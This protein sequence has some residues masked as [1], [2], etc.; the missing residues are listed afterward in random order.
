MK[1]ELFIVVIVFGLLSSVLL[2]G[3][4]ITVRIDPAAQTVESGQAVS[5]DVVV[6][7][8]NNLG[9][10]QFDI[11]FDTNILHVNTAT[12]GVFLG[13]TGRTVIPVGPDMNNSTNPGKITYGAATLGANTG[14]DGNGI[15]A[16]VEFTTQANGTATLELQNVQ[17]SDVDGQALTIASLSNGSVTVGSPPMGTAVTNTND[18]GEGS[19]RWAIEQ[20]NSTP[21]SDEIAFAIPTSDPGYEAA[22]GIWRI[23][24]ASELPALQDAGMNVDGWSQ[25]EVA[26]DVNPDGPEIVLDGS[27]T[28]EVISGL[29]VAA[30]DIAIYGL[31]I[32]NF[33]N[34]G[35]LVSGVKGTFISE[36]LIGTDHRGQNSAGN[37]DGILL[38]NGASETLVGSTEENHG[39]VISGN[40]RFGVFLSESSHNYIT[41][42]LIGI[43]QAETDTLGNLGHGI[44]IQYSS[45]SNHVLFNFIGGNGDGV[46]IFNSDS[47]EIMG[48]WIG[49]DSTFTLKYSQ[50]NDGIYLW[51]NSRYT[52]II[53]NVIGYNLEFGISIGSSNALYNH[54][55]ENS[56]S[57][58]SAAGIMTWSGGNNELA[59]PT[60]L[61]YAN[62][63]IQGQAQP[64]QII[65]VFADEADEG[66]VYLGYAESN[67]N[68]EFSIQL[69]DSPLFNNITATAT[70]I[71][72]NTSGFS[73]PF[74]ITAVEDNLLTEVPAKFSLQQNYPNPFNNATT[75]SYSVAA[76][77]KIR[78]RVFN[79]MGQESERLVDEVKDA[80]HYKISWNSSNDEKNKISSGIFFIK[81]EA[82]NY[83]QVI[84]TVLIK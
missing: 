69:N 50:Q 9:A 58:N 30:D 66:R 5:I 34:A 12:M 24:P 70:D 40:T 38:I 54:I 10:F 14:P 2:Y 21:E 76:R 72:G 79:M 83:N 46:A 17:L 11:V 60:I 16:S 26:G 78:I 43:N 28:S 18:S 71:N 75:I 37:N 4:D 25:Q 6:E 41:N 52:E 47:T 32:Q 23:K 44:S 19:L 22:N 82:G 51:G 55:S 49:T 20:A 27:A 29:L 53:Q 74:I 1:K 15:L 64:E 48:N 56:I 73:A 42:N 39:N 61:S 7:N 68:G 84:K 35:I 80:G 77:E 59:P 31:I 33:K 3:Q 62:M 67:G 13:S 36:C 65:E 8:V 57:R 63:H 81:L 45:H